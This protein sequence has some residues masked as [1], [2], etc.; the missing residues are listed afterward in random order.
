MNNN[1]FEN[2]YVLKGNLKKLK[3]SLKSFKIEFVPNLQMKL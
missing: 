1:Y 3:N 2:E